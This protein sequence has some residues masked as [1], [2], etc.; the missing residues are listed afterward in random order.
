MNHKS[1]TLLI[2]GADFYSQKQT[3]WLIVQQWKAKQDRE[4]CSDLYT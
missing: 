4:N 3:Q 1:V 2:R